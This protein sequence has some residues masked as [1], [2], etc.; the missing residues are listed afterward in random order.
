MSR[1]Q[2]RHSLGPSAGVHGEVMLTAVYFLIFIT[3]LV[4]GGS[5]A[6]LL[7]RLGLKAEETMPSPR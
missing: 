7:S 1:A 4:N 3:V 5:C 6:Y 2:Y